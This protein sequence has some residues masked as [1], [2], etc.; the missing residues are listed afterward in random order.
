MSNCQVEEF[1]YIGVLLT[2]E[3]RMEREIDRRIGKAAAIMRT[4]HRSVVVK[5]ELSEK[6]KL[7][8]YRFGLRSYP[9][10]WS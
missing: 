8:I 4:L 3:G 1:K 9:H 7:S 2:S 6:A 5:R 10:L